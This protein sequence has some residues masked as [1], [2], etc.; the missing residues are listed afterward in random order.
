MASKSLNELFTTDIKEITQFR[1]ITIKSFKLIK[2]LSANPIKWSNILKI[3]RGW[4]PL[5]SLLKIN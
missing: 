3:C 4:F 1:G 2:P 5:K